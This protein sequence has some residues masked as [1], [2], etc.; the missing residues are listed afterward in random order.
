MLP[1]AL[2]MHKFVKYMRKDKVF[3]STNGYKV[4]SNIRTHKDLERLEYLLNN[5]LSAV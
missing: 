2:D 5:E 3:E 1:S 4:V